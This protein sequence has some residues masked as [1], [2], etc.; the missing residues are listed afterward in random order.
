MYVMKAYQGIDTPIGGLRIDHRQRV[1]N[2]ELYPIE[3]L[4]AAGILCGGWLGRNYGFFGS[5]M[6]FVTYSGYTAGEICAA[7]ILAEQ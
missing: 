6:S 3:N 2:K 5:E 7:E 4:Y 1:L